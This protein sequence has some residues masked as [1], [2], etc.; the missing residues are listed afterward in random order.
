MTFVALV[1][2]ISIARPEWFR[3]Y[4]LLTL[5]AIVPQLCDVSGTRA[6]ERSYI[7]QLLVR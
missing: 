3:Q 7:L 6:R 4:G 2:S 5:M 1:Q